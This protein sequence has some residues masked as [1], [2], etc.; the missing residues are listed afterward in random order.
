MK[1]FELVQGHTVFSCSS[2]HWRATGTN[3]QIIIAVVVHVRRRTP[4]LCSGESY[5]AQCDMLMYATTAW[6]QMEEDIQFGHFMTTQDSF[7]GLCLTA[8]NTRL[9][10]AQSMGTGKVTYFIISHY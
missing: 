3:R 8:S 5:E 10:G 9:C 1:S 4:K 7:C 6:S 2:C